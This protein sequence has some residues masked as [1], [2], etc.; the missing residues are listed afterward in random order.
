MLVGALYLMK[1]SLLWDL[2]ML[3]HKFVRFRQ[4]WGFVVSGAFLHVILGAF[5]LWVDDI[6]LLVGTVLGVFGGGAFISAAVWSCGAFV[7]GSNGVVGLGPFLLVGLWSE[8]ELS[9]TLSCS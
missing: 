6:G 1:I 9:L 5:V 3:C 7:L 8:I 4:S 2:E